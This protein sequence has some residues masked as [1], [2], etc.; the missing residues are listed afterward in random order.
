MPDDVQT[1]CTLVLGMMAKMF[2]I[3][4]WG[5]STNSTKQKTDEEKEEKRQYKKK[6]ENNEWQICWKLEETEL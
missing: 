6:S 3:L 5:N 2:W 4:W 1:L